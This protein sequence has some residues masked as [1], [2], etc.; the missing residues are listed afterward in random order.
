MSVGNPCHQLTR[1]AHFMFLYKIHRLQTKLHAPCLNSVAT[2]C[3]IYTI[4]RFF[5]EIR[6]PQEEVQYL[7][8]NTLRYGK[9]D[10][11]NIK[12]DVKRHIIEERMANWTLNLCFFSAEEWNRRYSHLAKFQWESCYTCQNQGSNPN[13]KIAVSSTILN[14]EC[15]KWKPLENDKETQGL[16]Q[17]LKVL[18][19]PGLCLTNRHVP[20]FELHSYMQWNQ[21]CVRTRTRTN[22]D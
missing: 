13:D 18:L 11:A 7:P 6:Q 8:V 20:G 3:Y 17:S 1:R 12:L 10:A 2:V 9:W 22:R 16:L 14:T 19:K 4:H 15:T 5:P 21:R